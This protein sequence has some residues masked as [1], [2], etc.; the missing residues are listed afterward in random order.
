V[1][2][3]FVPHQRIG[4]EFCGPQAAGAGSNDLHL[5]LLAVATTSVPVADPILG[6][7][8]TLL[9][10]FGGTDY[11]GYLP[12]TVGAD[13]SWQLPLPEFLSS[14]TL[15]FQDWV[16]RANDGLMWGSGRLAVPLLR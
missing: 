4:S 6:T 13:V 15:Y 8:C 3:G 2:P 1:R 5:M 14:T 12:L 7:G 9:V 10:P 16:L 11:L